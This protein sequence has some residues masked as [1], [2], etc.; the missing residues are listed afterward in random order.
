[1]LDLKE[2]IINDLKS[3]IPLRY[4]RYGITNNEFKLILEE[5]IAEGII[6]FDIYQNILRDGKP[7]PHH[8]DPINIKLRK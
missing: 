4:R 1:M 8:G 5:L 6:I 3:G 2:K 7:H